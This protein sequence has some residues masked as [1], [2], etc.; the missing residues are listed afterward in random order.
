M[1]KIASL[2]ILSLTRCDLL[3][4][5]PFCVRVDKLRPANVLENFEASDNTIE[6]WMFDSDLISKL[7]SELAR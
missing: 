2:E 1:Y 6:I 7:S 4:I 5:Y 3:S